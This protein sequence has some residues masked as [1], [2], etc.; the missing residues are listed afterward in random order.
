MAV[1]GQRQA[2]A[3]LLSVKRLGNPLHRRLGGRL[4]RR[5]NIFPPL[6]FKCQTVQTVVRRSTHGMDYILVEML[7]VEG[8][9]RIINYTFFLF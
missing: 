7:H 6:G 3:A 5:G 4:W 2:T 8:I 1:G 9:K